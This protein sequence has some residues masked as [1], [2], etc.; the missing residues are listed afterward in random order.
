MHQL[1]APGLAVYDQRQPTSEANFIRFYKIRTISMIAWVV[2]D[3]A[4][5]K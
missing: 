1:A 3:G 4:F 5:L 2:T